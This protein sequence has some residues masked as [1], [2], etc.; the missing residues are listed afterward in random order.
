[1]THS[2]IVD[3]LIQ[4]LRETREGRVRGIMGQ[5]P[6][7]GDFFRIFSLA[8][9][10]GLTSHETAPSHQLLTGD[11]LRQT[12]IER[13]PDLAQGGNELSSLIS[14]WHE[15]CYAWDNYSRYNTTSK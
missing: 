15:W 5:E 9:R 10:Q 4:Y 14:L 7:K 11:A 1:M 6:Y 3:A 8:Y 13:A 12:I 2:E